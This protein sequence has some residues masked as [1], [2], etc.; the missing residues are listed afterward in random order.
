MTL[1]LGYSRFKLQASMGATAGLA[2]CP[3]MM[4]FLTQSGNVPIVFP[5]HCGD[6]NFAVRVPAPTNPDR[7]DDALLNHSGPYGVAH[8]LQGWNIGYR[9]EEPLRRKLPQ[10]FNGRNRRKRHDASS[11]A[12][13]AKFESPHGSLLGASRASGDIPSGFQSNQKNDL[14]NTTFNFFFGFVANALKREKV[15]VMLQFF[16]LLAA[17]GKWLPSVYVGSTM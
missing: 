14:F 11:F 2:F 1:K 16:G 6:N 17:L 7:R 10:L 12:D 5:T 4:L 8:D 13:D 3:D 9:H 15:G